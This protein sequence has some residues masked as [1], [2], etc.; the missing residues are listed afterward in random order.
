MER[1][2]ARASKV[3]V[4]GNA[5]NLVLTV[6]RFSVGTGKPSVFATEIL[7]QFTNTI[8]EAGE[9]TPYEKAS[10]IE[11]ELYADLYQCVV[12]QVVQIG[13]TK[14]QFH[15][16]KCKHENRMHPLSDEKMAFH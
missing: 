10:V 6:A 3:S 4:T 8:K 11:L 1:F 14:S 5:N 12:Q 2:C 7:C 9:C 13:K 15:A 16:W